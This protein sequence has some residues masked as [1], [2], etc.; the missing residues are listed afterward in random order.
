L[1]LGTPEGT[2]PFQEG[3]GFGAERVLAKGARP[4]RIAEVLRRIALRK[5][6]GPDA[7]RERRVEHTLEL[8]QRGEPGAGEWRTQSGDRDLS[9]DPPGV[10]RRDP[11]PDR[12]V[13]EVISARELSQVF[14]SP[15]S[16]RRPGSQPGDRRGDSV[17]PGSHP[18]TGSGIASS[19]GTGSVPSTSQLFVVASISD[20]LRKLL[21]DA[22]RRVFPERPPIDVSLPRG[23]EAARELVP[24][25][26]V[27]A[28][29]I[30]LDE[31]ERADLELTFVGAAAKGDEP[32]ARAVVAEAPRPAA[33]S[34][35]SDADDENRPKTSPGTPTSMSKRPPEPDG[36]R[37]SADAQAPLARPHLGEAPAMREDAVRPSQPPPRV[38]LVSSE[39]GELAPLGAL[40]L[41]GQLALGRLDVVLTVRVEDKPCILTLVRGELVAA[42]GEGWIELRR[43]ALHRVLAS[44]VGAGQATE[45]SR[46]E[47]T[48]VLERSSRLADEA[49]LGDVL[50][51]ARGAFS[52]EPREA[53]EPGPRLTQRPLAAMLLE[54]S[55]RVL[56]VDRV[57][58]FHVSGPDDP[59]VS[60]LE[61]LA[62]IEVSRTTALERVLDAVEAPRELGWL[63]RRETA[64]AA[65]TLA[66]LTTLAPDE[67]G[68]V[69]AV[70]ALAQLGGLTLTVLPETGSLAHTDLDARAEKAILALRER[71]DRADYFDVLGIARDADGSAVVEAHYRLR[72]ELLAWPLA[73]LGLARLEADRM[74]VLAVLDDAAEVLADARLRR[75]YSRGLAGA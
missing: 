16:P 67:P 11:P 60:R 66:S 49:V 7:S 47:P 23:E 65:T 20:E 1:L 41:L 26:F 4:E 31:P 72:T 39:R 59:T 56:G 61:R 2:G 25:D 63:L 74:R 42:A 32:R 50:A 14:D 51:K 52:L 21:Y 6:G 64:T 13:S 19:P 22:D 58:S 17:V 37:S 43:R 24:D 12:Q 71:A 33:E 27:E 35:K 70:F 45:L 44:S 18:G 40:A 5:K 48:F 75:R 34:A 57:L 30:A 73:D 36:T 28:I 10:V 55:R 69:G 29:S 53:R 15:E 62:R 54:L 38:A 3:P 9:R 8:G 68:L 46:G